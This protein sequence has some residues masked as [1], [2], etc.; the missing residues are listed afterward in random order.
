MSVSLKQIFEVSHRTMTLIFNYA[1]N[2]NTYHILVIG[3]L[4]S[5]HL[6]AKRM[7][8]L[9]DDSWPCSGPLL[10]LSVAVAD[11][12]LPGKVRYFATLYLIKT[13]FI[14]DCLFILN[15]SFRY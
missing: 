6:L 7:K 4:L 8:V 11:K 10:D 15:Y 13:D 2:E 12:I 3:G 14:F 5:A 1:D 9:V